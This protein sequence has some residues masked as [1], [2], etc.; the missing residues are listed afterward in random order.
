MRE[1]VVQCEW[2]R[3]S[4]CVCGLSGMWKVREKGVEVGGTCV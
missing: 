3:H 1:G 2:K 4:L